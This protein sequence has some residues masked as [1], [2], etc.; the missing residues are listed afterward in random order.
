MVE[1]IL[2]TYSFE[3]SLVFLIVLVASLLTK[4]P[5]RKLLHSLQRGRQESRVVTTFW[6][7]TTLFLV[8]VLSLAA[9]LYLEEELPRIT[10]L[11]ILVATISLIAVISFLVGLFILVFL[12]SKTG[13]PRWTVVL[14]VFLG[15]AGL[16][17][18]SN[19]FF[20]GRL[21]SPG[22]PLDAFDVTY[23]ANINFREK[24]LAVEEEYEIQPKSHYLLVGVDDEWLSRT[25]GVSIG[26][27][28]SF[29]AR[30]STGASTGLLV[31]VRREIEAEITRL[32]LLRQKLEISDWDLRV[33]VKNVAETLPKEEA[34]SKGEMSTFSLRRISTVSG[35]L[36]VR[37]PKNS[38]LG[39][40]PEGKLVKLP[41][42]DQFVLD[43]S[44]RRPVVELYYLAGLRLG[45]LRTFLSDSSAPDIALKT[46]AFIFWPVVLLALGATQRSLGDSLIKALQRKPQRRRA[47][48]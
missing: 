24:V 39:S 3:L 47:G 11:E 9:F 40:F 34:D 21:G 20:L 23:R 18:V 32:G 42:R 25:P 30:E 44:K 22:P 38:Y 8:S 10:A 43:F 7:A 1:L 36:D 26:L 37:L 41:D 16:T 15:F 17:M 29:E 35:K 46:I 5:L 45:L 12:Q 31:T 33:R 28:H 19:F 2:L 27:L 4:V 13:F 6:G 14:A 48:F